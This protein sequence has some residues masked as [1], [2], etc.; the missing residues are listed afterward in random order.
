LGN[1]N[2]G[3]SKAQIAVHHYPDSEGPA[4]CTA[5][6]RPVLFGEYCDIPYVPSEIF[7]DPG[8]RDL[9]GLRL[10]EMVELIDKAPGCLGGAIWSGLDDAF[11]LPAAR[12]RVMVSG[13]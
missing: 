10:A 6:A 11:Q 3:G 1:F 8:M 12:S 5:S 2:N 4:R 9:W 13:A 7:T